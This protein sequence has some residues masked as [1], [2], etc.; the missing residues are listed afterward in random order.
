MV[1]RTSAYEFEG[2]TVQPITVPIYWM[3]EYSQKDIV[4]VFEVNILFIMSEKEG[5]IS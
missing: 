5:L 1:V 2:D 4:I 3:T